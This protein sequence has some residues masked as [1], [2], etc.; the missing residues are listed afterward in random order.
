[1]QVEYHNKMGNVRKTECTRTIVYDDVGNPILV[2]FK[3]Q[4]GV[5][6]ASCVGQK[7]FNNILKMLGIDKTVICQP[8]STPD[9]STLPEINL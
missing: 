3:Y 7:D 1:M 8:L 5:C 2:A 6:Y 9:P 4:S